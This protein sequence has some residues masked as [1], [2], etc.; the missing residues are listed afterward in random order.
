[1]FDP[2]NCVFLNNYLILFVLDMLYVYHIFT[3]ILYS[4]PTGGHWM[5]CFAMYL[6][7]DHDR[8]DRPE[9]VDVSESMDQY[10]TKL[11]EQHETLQKPADSIH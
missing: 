1:M 7:Y 9:A 10:M 8:R 5:T 11:N 6:P 4:R 2:P 3:Y